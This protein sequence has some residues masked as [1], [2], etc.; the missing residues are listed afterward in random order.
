MEEHF[1][2]DRMDSAA[3]TTQF[4]RYRD[5]FQGILWLLEQKFCLAWQRRRSWCSPVDMSHALAEQDKSWQQGEAVH[6]AEILMRRNT[7]TRSQ[8]NAL[9]QEMGVRSLQCD[10]CHLAFRTP[11]FFSGDRHCPCCGE[12]LQSMPASSSVVSESLRTVFCSPRIVPDASKPQA[13]AGSLFLNVEEYLNKDLPALEEEIQSVLTALNQWSNEIEPSPSGHASKL[14]MPVYWS[15]V[16]NL[17]E[18]FAFMRQRMFAELAIALGF[19]NAKQLQRHLSTKAEKNLASGLLQK[20]LIGAE[21]SAEILRHLGDRICVC[22]S[23]GLSALTFLESESGQCP[24]CRTSF[25]AA[26]FTSESVGRVLQIDLLAPLM[27]LADTVCPRFSCFSG[28]QTAWRDQ[29]LSFPDKQEAPAQS[30]SEDDRLD[31]EIGEFMKSVAAIPGHSKSH[32]TRAVSRITRN[33]DMSEAQKSKVDAEIDR[34]LDSVTKKASDESMYRRYLQQLSQTKQ[35]PEHCQA[36]VPSDAGASRVVQEVSRFL[37]SVSGQP[38]QKNKLT[39]ALNVFLANSQVSHEEKQKIEEEVN[40]FMDSVTRE[41]SDE[42][43]YRRYVQQFVDRQANQEVPPQPAKP[44]EKKASP[45]RHCPPKPRKVRDSVIARLSWRRQQSNRSRKTVLFLSAGLAFLLAISWFVYRHNQGRIKNISVTTNNKPVQTPEQ[46]PVQMPVV[47]DENK[48]NEATA[49]PVPD[50]TPAT[51]VQLPPKDE[52]ISNVGVICVKIA[53]Y[54]RTIKGVQVIAESGGEEQVVV[55]AA[56]KNDGT[57]VINADPGDYELQLAKDG[58]RWAARQRVAVAAGQKVEVEMVLPRLGAIHG[59]LSRAGSPSTGTYSLTLVNFDNGQKMRRTISIS[60]EGEFVVADLEK[61]TYEARLQVPGLTT[62]VVK[63]VEVVAD[64]R[65]L[66]EFAWHRGGIE[67]YVVPLRAIN[68]R[69]QVLLREVMAAEDGNGI[70]AHVPTPNTALD[71]AGRFAFYG[72]K[73]GNYLVIVQGPLGTNSA[74]VNLE[75]DQSR[76]IDIVLDA[77]SLVAVQVF[78]QGAPLAGANV[79]ATKKPYGEISTSTV[80][81]KDGTAAFGLLPYGT[82]LFVVSGH[83]AAGGQA[84][85]KTWVL[86]LGANP[87]SMPVRVDLSSSWQQE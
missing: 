36:A 31:A 16:G 60:Q 41:S 20:E 18:L 10:R 19:L 76:Q 67:G 15:Y 48:G 35:P 71:R 57:C 30:Q 80:S 27:L 26:D 59:L 49:R 79:Y 66:V 38:P 63:K 14:L 39:E 73:P 53:G 44:E 9:L 1:F 83:A 70:L 56:V 28:E 69:T 24:R 87:T 25:A 5:R 62:P 86:D 81:G 64:A 51:T 42:S 77:C 33:M 54:K 43:I 75:Q 82:Y 78:W 8:I 32:I 23:C 4:R 45:A 34:F 61:G 17:E 11:M 21:E 12:I 58:Y 13:D 46:T 3:L 72:L 37:Q 68:E 2:T 40:R 85:R 50:T 74:Q 55:T 29:L 65:A 52:A 7:L 6:L 47:Q 22:S 84:L